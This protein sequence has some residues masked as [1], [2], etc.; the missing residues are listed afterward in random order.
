MRELKGRVAVV[1]GAA[2]G[3]GL[4]LS[5][6]AAAEGMQVVLADIEETA[7]QAALAQVQAAGAQA[8]AVKTDVSKPES[9]EA[10]AKAA[11][12]AIGK[13]HL[14]FNNAGVGAVRLKA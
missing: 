7:L 13:V 14:V 5:L 10:L 3:I 9:V 2:S 6:R 4:A 1:T 11:L 8:I 12:A